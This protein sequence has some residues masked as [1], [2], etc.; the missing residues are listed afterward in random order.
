MRAP[1]R[2]AV[3][4]LL[5]TLAA[6]GCGR[7]AGD[8]RSLVAPAA[9][10]AAEVTTW[11]VEAGTETVVTATGTLFPAQ[12]IIVMAEIPGKIVR[13]HA[14]EGDMV[15]AGAPLADLDTTDYAMGLRKAEADQQAAQLA[16]AE[17]RLEFDRMKRLH[18]E[19]A[20]AQA[21]FDGM[22]LKLDLTENGAKQ[23][24]IGMDMARRRI[25]QTTLRAPFDALVVNRLASL[26]TVVQVM[27]PTVVY[28]LQDARNLR[29]KAKV[30][31]LSMRVV[32]VGDR[33]EARFEALDRVVTAKVDTVVPSVD[34]M[35][36][37]FDVVA[38][39]DNQAF[40]MALKPGMF[41]TVRIVHAGAS[42][43]LLLPRDHTAAIVGR[44]GEVRAF[45]V[46]GGK[47]RERNVK[48][49]PVDSTTLAVLDGLKAGDEV[50]TSDLS[51]LADGIPVTVRK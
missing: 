27:P 3:A 13:L 32:S 41:A 48:V 35:S 46:E 40:D 43:R 36:R 2:G 8:G 21:A 20:L 30:P 47:A 33:L 10:A 16:L 26:G 5:A 24:V 4:A 51:S 15:K 50:V 14:E 19:G 34:P 37:T 1:S 39:L 9:A 49:E 29:L 23:A 22:K 18:D 44:P 17:T 12:E 38:E 45:V 31:E 7:N 11:K 25:S 28:R 6:A 42:N